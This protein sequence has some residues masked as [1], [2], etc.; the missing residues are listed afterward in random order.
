M[1]KTLKQR[2]EIPPIWLL[3]II[4]SMLILGIFFRFASLDGKIYWQ[5]ETLTSLRISGYH[6]REFIQNVFN[7][8]V[9]SVEDLLKFQTVNSSERGVGDT[10]KAL[11]FD[12]QYHPPLYYV[13][14]HLW[15]QIFGSSIAAIRS[16]SAFISL[17][18]FPG[19]YWLCL[20]LFGSSVTGWLAVALIAVSPFQIH[21]AQEARQYSLLIVAVLFTSAALLRAIRV[22]TKL[23]WIIYAATVT[24]GLY[25]NPLF[26]LVTITQGCYVFLNDNFRFS[27][28]FIS[29]LLT[30]A[31]GFLTF[32]PWLIII[33]NNL[34]HLQT[35]SAWMKTHIPL[36]VFVE[37]WIY[38]LNYAFFKPNFNLPFGSGFVIKIAILSLIGYALYFILRQTPKRVWLFVWLLALLPSITL[39]IP[40]LINGGVRSTIPRYIIPYYTGIIVAA[41]Y[42]FSTK[43]TS[44]NSKANQQRLWKFLLVAI[45]SLSLL[46]NVAHLRSGILRK[47]GYDTTLDIARLINQSS[48]PLVL[49]SETANEIDNPMVSDVLSVC[50]YLDSQVKLQLTVE[51]N[52]PDIPAGFENIFV[53][54]PIES[55]KQALQ[56]KYTLKP[57]YKTTLWRLER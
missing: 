10:V 12:S 31:V 36:R 14:A 48:Q 39:I 16:I 25:T 9:F 43:I 26:G 45:V 27:K 46:S 57:I 49:S 44:I 19:I 15:A 42:L 54:K 22:K 33:V 56:Q 20:E 24:V 17:L 2:W 23:S 1:N 37:Q 8:Q 47:E 55:F 21:Y 40:D 13:A 51:P 35:I 29:Y 52:L 30:S 41:A 5:D 32:L 50:H 34:S 18:A 6:T 4:I 38:N 28:N 11:A 7:H 3:I 53:F